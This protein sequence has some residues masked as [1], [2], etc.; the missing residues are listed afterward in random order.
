MKL[1]LIAVALSLTSSLA[2][3]DYTFNSHNQFYLGAAGGYGGMISN[4]PSLPLTLSDSNTVTDQQLRNGVAYRADLGYLWAVDHDAYG[5]EV[6]YMG[7]PKNTYDINNTHPSLVYKGYAADLLAVFQHNYDDGWDVNAK[8]GA[9]YVRQQLEKEMIINE[10]S[11][12]NQDI[13]NL[14]QYHIATYFDNESV[15]LPRTEFKTG[16]RLTKSISDRIKGKTGRI[17]SNLMGKRVDFSARTVIT[18]D[19]YIDIDQVGVPKKI[20][21]ELTIPEEVTP[22]NIKY[23]TF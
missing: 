7:Y 10:L 20:A 16:G 17:R 1:K 14:L 22:Y 19:P 9:A 21:M 8:L 6:G 18:P 3:A 12:Y 4:Q 23:L 2:L 15:S 13:F 5:F 11:S